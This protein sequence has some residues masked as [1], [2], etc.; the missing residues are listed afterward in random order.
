MKL[1]LLFVRCRAFMRKRCGQAFRECHE[2]IY[3]V[4]LNIIQF[5]FC[6]NFVRRRSVLASFGSRILQWIFCP[7]CISYSLQIEKQETS[8]R[9]VWF[10]C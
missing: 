6:N 9:F 3:C 10:T 8:L 4:Q 7:L 5:Y 1:C 2:E